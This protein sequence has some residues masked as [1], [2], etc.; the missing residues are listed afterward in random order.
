M[1]DT[2]H[3]IVEVAKEIVQIR[4]YLASRKPPAEYYLELYEELKRE[5]YSEEACIELQNAGITLTNEQRDCLTSRLLE[6]ERSLLS[7]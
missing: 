1:V 7:M 4:S 6:L 5:G 2:K 3:G